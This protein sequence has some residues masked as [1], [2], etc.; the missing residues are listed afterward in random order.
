[1][2]FVSPVPAIPPS[3]GMPAATLQTTPS[4]LV[5]VRNR[6]SP[7]AAGTQLVVPT[8]P[9]SGDGALHA[10]KAAHAELSASSGAAAADIV[11][12]RQV[13]LVQR[14]RNDEIR[15]QAIAAFIAGDVDGAAQLIAQTR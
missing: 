13:E 5:V 3:T 8:S 15:K 12:G 11:L 2:T 1:M 6:L 4:G 10:A 14:V 9:I 7:V